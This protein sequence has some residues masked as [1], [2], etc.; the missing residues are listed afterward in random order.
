MTRIIFTAAAAFAVLAAPAFADPGKDQYAAILGVDGDLFTMS[1]LI[2]LDDA[3]SANNQTEVRWI[4]DGG[5]KASAPEDPASVTPSEAQ[6]AA[7][8]GLDP[9]QYTTAEL[10]ALYAEKVGD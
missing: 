7:S 8:L 3:I 9:A 4:L 2:R 6:L 1:E 10:T 5:L